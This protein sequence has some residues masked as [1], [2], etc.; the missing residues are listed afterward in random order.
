MT[1]TGDARDHYPL[2][3]R[4]PDKVLTATGKPLADF[5]LEAVVAGEIEAAD[6][7]IRPETLR[8]QA[9]V[10]RAGS[11]D[12]LAENFE[13]AAE[14]VAVPQALLLDTY[15]LLRPGRA[16]SA[17]SMRARADELRARFGA[18]RIAA[19]IDEAADVYERRGLFKTRF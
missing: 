9:D 18:E 2:S 6:L 1:R 16:G 12:R 17:D 13:R 14:L 8:L 15:E 4:M 10:A 3:E 19:L 7:G 11:R 5:T